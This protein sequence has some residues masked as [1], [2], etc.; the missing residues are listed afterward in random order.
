VIHKEHMYYEV[1]LLLTFF[2]T[3]VAG[4]SLPRQASSST[5]LTMPTEL[6]YVWYGVSTVGG[7]LGLLGTVLIAVPRRWLLGKALL[8][9]GLMLGLLQL[10]GYGLAVLG[11]FDLKALFVGAILLS[12]AWGAGRRVRKISGDIKDFRKAFSSQMEGADGLGDCPPVRGHTGG[13]S[14]PDAA[15]ADQED[16]SRYRKDDG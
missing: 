4:L 3:G 7:G 11:L 16:E 5:L 9:Y 10:T 14:G 2:L 6:L 12:F 15:V 1:P 13:W 8:R